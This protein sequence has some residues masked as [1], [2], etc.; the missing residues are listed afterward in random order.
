MPPESE[1]KTI[2]A[3]VKAIE[4][5]NQAYAGPASWMGGLLARTVSAPVDP[6]GPEPDGAGK[7]RLGRGLSYLDPQKAELDWPKARA[8]FS[9]LAEALEQGGQVRGGAER[10][11]EAVS[12]EG[13]GVFRAMLCNDVEAVEAA[14]KEQG[15]DP[16]VL[17][18]L[19]RLA[20]RPQLKALARWFEGLR[21]AEGWDQGHCP[22]CGAE[23]ILASLGRDEGR[24]RLHCGLC[25]SAWSYPRIKCPF[26]GNQDHEKLFYVK[27]EEEEGL[28]AEVCAEC[29][30]HLR[31]IDL[32]KIDE[33]VLVPLDEVA[34]WH[35]E[36]LVRRQRS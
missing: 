25:E 32:R 7:E 11:N 9:E 35:L 4:A 6:P 24:R 15:I 1:L 34:T 31:T 29:G 20:L 28:R 3:K 2:E 18:L 10:L 12:G 27:A 30:R 21:L 5:R 13:G 16:P 14:A 8:L 23:P 17:A 33:P 22:L 19:L 26:C 36:E